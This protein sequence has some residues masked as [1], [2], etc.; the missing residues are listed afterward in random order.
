MSNLSKIKLMKR[1]EF[2]SLGSLATLGLV[3]GQFPLKAGS[4]GGFGI[5]QGT[6]LPVRG[7][8]EIYINQGGSVGL[9]ASKE[10]YIV[11]DSQFPQTISEV[12][13]KISETGKPILYL[14][15][16]HHHGD[17]TSGNNLFKDLSKGLVAHRTVPQSQK[18]SAE[19]AGT[20]GK[21]K[22]ADILFDKEFQFDLTDQLVKGYH[23]GAGHTR[24]DVIYHFE[25]DNVVHMGDLVFKDMIP[26]FRSG[27]GATIEGWINCLEKTS[28]KFDSDTKFIFGHAPT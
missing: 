10:G 24:G 28:E 11:V 17:H 15:N 21:Q 23:L 4:R 22:Y 19:K 2:L 20:L 12:L 3:L 18:N 27:D 13:L 5:Y 1:K 16:T 8:C 9:F 14:A 7:L 25:S 26:V 6:F